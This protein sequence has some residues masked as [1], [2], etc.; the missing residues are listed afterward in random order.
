MDCPDS[1]PIFSLS[2]FFKARLA[3][4]F[5]GRFQITHGTILNWYARVTFRE[6]KLI[7]GT[8]LFLIAGICTAQAQSDSTVFHQGLP[9]SHD[10][11][12]RNFPHYDYYPK[13]RMV[14]VPYEQLPHKLQRSLKEKDLYKGWDQFP[15]YY[16]KNTDIYDIRFM[17]GSDTTVVGMNKNGKPVTY[18]KRSKDDQ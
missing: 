15:V 11:T 12:V 2:H 7:F 3:F 18:G 5:S 9:V 17:D 16:D 1:R 14:I 8:C 6:M 4:I 10:D 13:T